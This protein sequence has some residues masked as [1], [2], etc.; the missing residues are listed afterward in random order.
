M[1]PV[2]DMYS[3]MYEACAIAAQQQWGSQ[4]IYIPE[5][6]YFDGLEKLPDD[7]AAEMRDLYLLRKPWDQRSAKF[8]EYSQHRHPHS[9]RWNWIQKA[10]L[11][12]WQ[13]ASITERGSGPYGPVSHILGTSAKIAYLFWRRYEYTLDRRMAAHAR[14]SHAER[15]GGVLSQFPRTLKKGATASITSTTSTATRGVWGAR[16][17]DEDLS[18][19]RG[20]LAA[21]LRAS[22]ILEVD[23]RAAPGLARVAREPRAAADQRRSGGPR[24][25]TATPARESSSADSSPPSNRA[26]LLPD[27]NS[28]PMW[29][30]DLCNVESRDRQTL[31]MAQ[32]HLRRSL[33]RNGLN[34]ADTG[35][36]AFEAR[37]SRR[38]RWGARMRCAF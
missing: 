37:R 13:A 38:H 2:F 15:R 25:P 29:L 19:M 5:T 14:L 1:D 36:G 18:A 26:A 33:F 6:M 7:I 20:V 27:A 24:S 12:E 28:L 30:F 32:H 11:G 22:E 17:T 16:D 10:E 3:G 21:L 31:E 23:E 9:S 34:A 8:I 4:G 35:F